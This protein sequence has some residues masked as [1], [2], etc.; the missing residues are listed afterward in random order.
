[1]HPG[2]RL[3][4]TASRGRSVAP[5]RVVHTECVFP[6]EPGCGQKRCEM[7]NPTKDSAYDGIARDE[8]VIKDQFAQH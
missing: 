6:G 3:G 4:A 2:R 1:M 7:A 5:D 8:N